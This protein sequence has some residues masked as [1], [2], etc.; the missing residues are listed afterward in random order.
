VAVAVDHRIGFESLA[1]E[2]L[3]AGARQ[4]V[5]RSGD[6]VLRLLE[7]TSGFAEPDWCLRGHAGLVLEGELNVDFDGSVVHFAAGD[8]LL[9]PSGPDH[10][11]K[12]IV[13]SEIT[14]LVLVE[15]C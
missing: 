11:H 1:W 14:R 13:I 5:F 12:A 7:F 3:A 10:R 4:K 15:H 2:D 6:T 8:G 9:I